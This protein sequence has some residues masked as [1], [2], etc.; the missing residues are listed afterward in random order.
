MYRCVQLSEKLC[1]WR[2]TPPVGMRATGAASSFGAAASFG[3]VTASSIVPSFDDRSDTTP[4]KRKYISPA[5][6]HQWRRAYSV[7]IVLLLM[8]LGGVLVSG[9]W[10][11]LL[12]DILS[13]VRGLGA[14]GIPLLIVC[15]MLFFLALLPISPIHLGIGVLYGFWPGLG[16]SWLAYTVGCVPPFLL[17]KTPL[18]LR[19]CSRLRH[20]EVIEGVMGALEQEPFKI[21]I[22]LRLSPLLPSPLNSYLLGFTAVPVHVYAS[23]SAVGC[24]PNVAAYVYLGSLLD[25]LADIAAGRSKPPGRTSWALLAVGLV[26]TVAVLVYVSRAATARVAA[27]RLRKPTDAVGC[28]GPLVV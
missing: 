12:F 17:A 9:R 2:D 10:R 8:A 11:T 19:A 18:V 24:L 28:Q 13:T 6:S 16:L 1:R 22:C 15:E 4:S 25:S 23:A 7:A 5:A 27:A 21:I 14:A 3:T 26:A 20:S